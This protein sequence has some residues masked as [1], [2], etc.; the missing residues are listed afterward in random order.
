MLLSGQESIDLV[1]SYLLLGKASIGNRVL[2]K[3]KNTGLKQYIQAEE[4]L[5]LA[6]WAILK[7]QDCDAEVQGLLHRN[8]GLLYLSQGNYDDALQEL[9]LD[10]SF[11]TMT[12]LI[13]KVYYHSN[14]NNPEHIS[15]NL[16]TQ[17]RS[18]TR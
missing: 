4:Y 12:V 9:A 7:V 16:I 1:P 5:S 6:K 17:K 11:D 15:G 8:I 18:L 10:V 2:S 3:I 13:K 14:A